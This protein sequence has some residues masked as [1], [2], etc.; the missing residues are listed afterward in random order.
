LIT[1]FKLTVHRLV[2]LAEAHLRAGGGD[3]DVEL[4]EEVRVLLTA[5]PCVSSHLHLQTI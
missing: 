4:L 3:D 1:T 2:R 5:L